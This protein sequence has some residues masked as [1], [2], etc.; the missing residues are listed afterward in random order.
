ME[1]KRKEVSYKCIF[2]WEGDNG[3]GEQLIQQIIR[4]E[5]TATCAPKESYSEEELQET[6]ESVGYVVPVYDKHGNERCHI[7]MMDVF[8][9][10]FGNPDL[11]L[12]QGEGNGTNVE[13]FQREHR[14]AWKEDVQNGLQLND[15]TIL[16]VEL[17][18][19]VQPSSVTNK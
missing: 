19:Y 7:K 3:L 1:N 8:E 5:K 4:G 18:E 9:T 14:E 16:I 2:G 13:E 10:T 17:F 11:R 15:S 12:V 6:Y